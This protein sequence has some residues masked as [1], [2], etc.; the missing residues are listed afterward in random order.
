M[1]SD[2]PCDE[3]ALC[4]SGDGLNSSENLTSYKLASEGGSGGRGSRLWSCSAGGQARDKWVV[5]AEKVP[6]WVAPWYL[7]RGHK[8]RRPGME[9]GPWHCSHDGSES[10]ALTGM[11]WDGTGSLTRGSRPC[12]SARCG[13]QTG[14][15]IG[16]QRIHRPC[17]RRRGGSHSGCHLVP[18]EHSGRRRRLC[19][20]QG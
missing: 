6:M 10:W 2:V 14:S 1:K 18:G 8:G 7:G 13:A 19:R 20:A 3:N 5:E 9:A 15:G 4:P 12:A 16:S 17:R 11:G